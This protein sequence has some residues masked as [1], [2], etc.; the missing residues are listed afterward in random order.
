MLAKLVPDGEGD[1]QQNTSSRINPSQQVRTGKL[2]RKTH[3]RSEEDIHANRREDKNEKHTNP[4]LPD[5][6]FLLRVQCLS[7]TGAAHLRDCRH[8]TVD[9]RTA[10]S[11]K[12]N[13]NPNPI[14]LSKEIGSSPRTAHHRFDMTYPLS[15][16]QENSSAPH[17]S[18]TYRTS[19]LEQ[20]PTR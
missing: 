2:P 18:T 7:Y 13:R 9:T 20:S 14:Y 3:P 19:N 15:C 16:F 12:G 11:S 17:A 1:I 4:T 10:S 8:E 5:N 6:S